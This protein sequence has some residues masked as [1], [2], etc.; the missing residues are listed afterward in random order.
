MG[1]AKHAIEERDQAFHRKAVF[2][3]WRCARCSMVVIYDE[4][5][6]YFDKGLCGYCAHVTERND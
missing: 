5:D 2:E 3:G 6:V 1:A 4:R